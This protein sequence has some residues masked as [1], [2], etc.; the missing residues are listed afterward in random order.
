MDQ[1]LS[2]YVFSFLLG[3]YL[4]VELLSHVVTLC[5]PKLTHFRFPLAF[6]ISTTSLPALAALVII[7]HPHLL[8]LLFFFP[9]FF[10][11]IP[12]IIIIIITI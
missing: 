10:S 12:I 2:G 9:L 5:L 8:L 4:R 1:F 6:Y 7:D 11:F 3:I